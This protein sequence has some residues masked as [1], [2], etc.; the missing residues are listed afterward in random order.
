MRTVVNFADKLL[1]KV[2]FAAID[3]IIE[4]VRHIAHP[5]HQFVYRQTQAASNFLQLGSR[6]AAGTQFANLENIGI[7]PAF[8]Q[9]PFGK[10]KAARVVQRQQFFLIVQDFIDFL[11]DFVV[12]VC[13]VFGKIAAVA[14]GYIVQRFLQVIAVKRVGFR[15]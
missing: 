9:R 3:K 13:I 5:H 4:F 1:Y 2:F 14:G 6:T 12:A 15:F 11:F 8:A 7:V 10:N